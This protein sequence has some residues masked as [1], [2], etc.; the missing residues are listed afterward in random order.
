M[1]N[2]SWFPDKKGTK[3]TPFMGDLFTYI[4]QLLLYD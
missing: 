3:M 1:K 2:S 4:G